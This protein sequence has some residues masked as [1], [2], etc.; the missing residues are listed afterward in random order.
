M[1][2]MT[3]CCIKA[4]LLR[5]EQ[6]LTDPCHV[7]SVHHLV[8]ELG[9]LAS[10]RPAHMRHFLAIQ[11]KDL[12]CTIDGFLRAACHYD[13]IAVLGADVAARDWS[14]D[15]MDLSRVSFP[16]YRLCNSRAACR[17]VDQGRSGSHVAQNAYLR[18]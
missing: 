2:M 1:P 16:R 17:V 13:K 18:I 4:C 6:R 9:V 10:A 15:R 11:P 14:I 8:G 7:E 5:V 3:C 12:S